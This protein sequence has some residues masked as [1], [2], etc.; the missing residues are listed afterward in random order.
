M[1]DVAADAPPDAPSSPADPPAAPAQAMS[2]EDR[3]DR[4]NWAEV[5]ARIPTNSDPESKAARNV[6]YDRIAE[7][8]KNW[9][10]SGLSLTDVTAGITN[11][12]QPL[13]SSR[14]LPGKEL[15]PGVTDLAPAI[16]CAFT[17][18]KSPLPTS[19]GRKV[20]YLMED[21][22]DEVDRREF[23]VLLVYLRHYLELQVLYPSADV[24]EDF[25]LSWDEAMKA[26]PLLVTWG[27]EKSDIEKRFPENAN[28][29]SRELKF[30][31][32]ADWCLKCKL[33]SQ[34]FDDP[35]ERKADS[36]G[37]DDDAAAS[38]QNF[39]QST[40]FRDDVAAD[41]VRNVMEDA[42]ASN[43][44][45]FPVG[46]PNASGERQQAFS[47]DRK[48]TGSTPTRQ[49]PAAPS[50]STSQEQSSSWNQSSTSSLPHAKSTSTSSLPHAKSTG[51]LFGRSRSRTF[52]STS[53]GMSP[54]GGGG[55]LQRAPFLTSLSRHRSLPKI[56]FSERGAMAFP[57]VTNANPGPGSYSIDDQGTSKFRR[58]PASSTSH[59]SRFGFKENPA[60]KRPAPGDYQ[61]KNPL[62]HMERKVGF[63]TAPRGRLNGVRAEGPGPGAYEI[64]K[65]DGGPAFKQKGRYPI[66]YEPLKNC[67]GPGNY[68]PKHHYTSN[69][70]RVQQ[71]GFGTSAREDFIA[72]HQTPVPG[73][74]LYD[75]DKHAVIGKH[76]MKSS[77]RS[78][79][80]D[81]MN[82][83]TYVTPA[84][85]W[86]DN[87]A[88]SFGY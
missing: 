59:S 23:H 66:Q 86:Y 76:S 57:C 62:H 61:P 88:T 9:S 68:D 21:L 34:Q 40:G 79:P 32:F 47:S 70:K 24:A 80:R 39:G 58:P 82:F 48:A 30:S 22:D 8:R 19:P 33:G 72:K 12:L 26:G 53:Y 36:G 37:F 42:S 78:R 35:A 14:T 31:E 81:P 27:I 71:V 3:G 84:P 17:A 16:K 4:V 46:E 49:R 55:V 64:R 1:T 15:A 63:S 74:G 75:V 5:D 41:S 83:N 52:N 85:G 43:T 2:N 69:Q 13:L 67:P 25:A 7:N 6:L 87:H 11:Q 45:G 54:R 18:S 29:T 56:T 44:S 51:S 65:L 50:V 38:S 10:A 60:K 73:P 28:D 77:I 20:Q